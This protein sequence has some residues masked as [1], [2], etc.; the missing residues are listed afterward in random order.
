MSSHFPR[1]TGAASAA[2]V[3]LF[4]VGCDPG[5]AVEGEPAVEARF[6]ITGRVLDALTGAGI[7]QAVVT[8]KQLG[9]GTTG[10]DGAYSFGDARALISASPAVM[11]ISAPGYAPVVM[12]VRKVGNTVLLPTVRM[13]PL[14]APVLTGPEGGMLRFENGVRLH[15]PEGAI[16]SAMALRSAMP[17]SVPMPEQWAASGPHYAAVHIGPESVQFSK[18]IRVTVPL[19]VAGRPGTSLQVHTFRPSTEEWVPA[20]TGVIAANGVT[21]DVEIAGTGT[22]TFVDAD[23]TTT[24]GTITDVPL[25]DNWGG[26]SDCIEGP[27]SF[28][29]PAFQYDQGFSPFWTDARLNDLFVTLYQQYGTQLNVLAAAGVASVGPK[30]YQHYR[31]RKTWTQYVVI[32][33]VKYPDGSLASYTYRYREFAGWQPDYKACDIQGLG[34]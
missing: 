5:R 12:G 8:F 22:F 20:G 1:R 15:V 4:L 30:A 27:E 28:S 2:L 17:T 34:N 16:P 32:A 14:S 6:E 29:A 7:P 33:N 25:E 10:P 13:T 26:W 18:P 31:I 21:A 9:G 24:E 3:A 11:H 23:G 19:T